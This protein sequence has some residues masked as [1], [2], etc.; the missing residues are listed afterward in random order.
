[1]LRSLSITFM[2]IIILFLSIPLVTRYYACENAFTVY[3][4]LVN[5]NSVSLFK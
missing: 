5:E 4:F 1:M 2:I 3:S